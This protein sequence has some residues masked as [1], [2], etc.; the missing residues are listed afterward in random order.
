VTYA[1]GVFVAAVRELGWGPFRDAD[2]CE[3]EILF[4]LREQVGIAPK[5]VFGVA[6]TQLARHP[7]D[8]LATRQCTGS[9]GVTS[10]V[11]AERANAYGP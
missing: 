5:C 11:E 3:R 8:A 9:V 7:K 1:G 6:V 10:G 4:L 2:F